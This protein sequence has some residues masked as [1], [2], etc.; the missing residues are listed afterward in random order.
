MR[1]SSHSA[2]QS[3]LVVRAPPPLPAAEST[4]FTSDRRTLVHHPGRTDATASLIVLLRTWKR[5][6]S[7]R[8]SSA[9]CR[10]APISN[11]KGR[12]RRASCRL[13]TL[14]LRGTSSCRFPAVCVAKAITAPGPSAPIILAN[15]PSW[16][17]LHGRMSGA[18][19]LAIVDV[20]CSSHA[21]RPRTRM[22]V[23]MMGQRPKSC[24]NL[25]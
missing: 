16:R 11:V 5:T 20:C 8:S 10:Y 17:S 3:R 4:W 25:V 21:E 18:G 7:P 14:S 9:R 12:T 24:S 13:A 2:R 15:A 23:S 1:E 22:G 6:K 19:R